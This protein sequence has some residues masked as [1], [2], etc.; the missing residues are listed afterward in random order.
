VKKTMKVA[1]YLG[2]QR[3][4]I[5]D[6]KYPKVASEGIIIKIMTCGVCGSDLHVFKEGM[7]LETS[8]REIDG[9]RV[10]GHEFGGEIVEV[11]EKVV[12]FKV[13]ERVTCAHTKGG[14]AE[15]IH[16][17]KVVKNVNVFHLPD[18]ISYR[19]AATLE[20]LF[21][22]YH[23]VMLSAPEVGETAVVIGG[24]IVGLGV[25]Q[26]LKALYFTK[27]IVVDLSEKRL[28]MA[29]TLGADETINPSRENPVDKVGEVTGT[30][31]VRYLT[32][33]SPLA[34]IVY[35]CAGAGVTP[36]Q[37][38]D[39]AKPNGGRVVII[40]LYEKLSSVDFNSMVCKNMT[41]YGS[42]GY[43][44]KDIL[45]TLE[46]V[47]AGRIDRERL[48]THDFH[49]GDIQKAFESQLKLSETIKAIVHMN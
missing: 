23:G 17:E 34:D 45:Q 47:K 35:E 29:R 28:E 16:V 27:I 26:I 11:G 44:S 38:F 25:V 42:L 37:A 39:V 30:A 9:N 24:G 19:T 49:L 8:S 31:A 6:V 43:S 1:A 36:Q 4:G 12:D 48:I 7:F 18:E 14:Y 15:Y 10:L 21:T 46:V 32:K 2:K 33:P 41:V 40:A 3:I 22:S 5:V 13:G 20:P